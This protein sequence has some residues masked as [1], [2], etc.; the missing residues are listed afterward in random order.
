MKHSRSG[1]E[2]GRHNMGVVVGK[3]VTVVG[4]VIGALFLAACRGGQPA[5]QPPAQPPAA[6]QPAAPAGDGQ[7]VK[8][9]MSEFKFTMA[10]GEV[11]TETVS[12]ELVNAGSVEHNF[13]IEG[14]SVK[15][16]HI[17]AGQTV[18]VQADLAP[19]TYKVVCD[20]AGHTEAGMA[21]ELVVK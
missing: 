10:P 8:V 2:W 20:V 9:E 12:F 14:T 19:G 4:L 6:Q 1:P 11:K 21:T 16:E 18:M 13:I 7:A 5:Q 17:G 3:H 15:S